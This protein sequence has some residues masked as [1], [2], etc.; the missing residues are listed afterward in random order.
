MW[1]DFISPMFT[2]S[3]NFGYKSFEIL[4]STKTLFYITTAYIEPVRNKTIPHSKFVKM[5]FFVDFTLEIS[6]EFE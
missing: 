6:D 3:Y 5:L 1:D 2:L 4:I